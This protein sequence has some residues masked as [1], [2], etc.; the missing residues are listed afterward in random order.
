[1]SRERPIK[2]H[3][4]DGKDTTFRLIG[5]KGRVLNSLSWDGE[6]LELKDA[7]T[8]DV[9]DEPDVI[10]ARNEKGQTEAEAIEETQADHPGKTVVF[11]DP[12]TPPPAAP[13][14][15]DGA[16]DEGNEENLQ[17]ILE[18]EPPASPVDA[19]DGSQEPALEIG[20]VDGIE[21]VS[22]ESDAAMTDDELADL[23][24]E[25]TAKSPDSEE[26]PDEPTQAE[27]SKSE[28]DEE[29]KPPQ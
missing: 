25:D 10:V 3:I 18:D 6:R 14:L 16:K 12:D 28:D 22:G 2:L 26:S 1:M 17:N 15:N 9:K 8:D 21:D 5:P 19:P 4:K 24:E 23:L 20:A 13:E 27:D 29:K 11:E 7:S